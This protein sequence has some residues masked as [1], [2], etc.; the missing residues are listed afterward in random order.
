MTA[1]APETPV[2][3]AFLGSLLP[4]IFRYLSV[5]ALPAILLVTWQIFGMFLSRQTGSFFPAP[6]AVAAA[7]YDWTTGRTGSTLIY[8][9]ELYLAIGASLRRVLLAY[10]IACSLAIPLGILVGWVVGFRRFADPTLQLLRPIPVS[11]WVPISMLWFGI[12]DG[13]AIYLITLAAFF[14]I[15][16]NTVQGVR[17]V[18]PVVIRA[19]RMLGARYW[20]LFAYV[21]FPSILPSIFAGLR[22]SLGFAWMAVV[23]SELVAVKNGLGYVMFDAYGFLRADIVIAAMIVIGLLG[24]L[25][26][27]LMIFVEHRALGWR[28][29]SARV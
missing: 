23:V 27:K 24:F 28:Q 3:D 5:L 26:D 15:Y 16:I 22:I 1:P 17:Y 19:G 12:G 10:S 6:S 2:N 14:P 4:R 20:R 29:M 8:S 9:G 11:A 25:S 18:D 21:V 13:A 7:L